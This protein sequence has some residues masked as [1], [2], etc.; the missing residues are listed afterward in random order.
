MLDQLK[1]ITAAATAGVPFN[2]IAARAGLTPNAWISLLANHK[3]QVALAIAIGRAQAQL[4][5]NERLRL[6]A[7]N[8]KTAAALYILRHWHKWK[9]N[10]TD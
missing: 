6:C 9:I 1:E 7:L 10:L 5:V 3:Q 2:D 4:R 8:G